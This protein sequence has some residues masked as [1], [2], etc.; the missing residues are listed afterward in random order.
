MLDALT[1]AS[2]RQLDVSDPDQRNKT[3][4]ATIQASTIQL[5]PDGRERFA[6]LAIFAEDET[7][8]RHAGGITVAGHR[9]AGRDGQ[10]GVRPAGGPGPGGADSR[11]GG[12]TTH[13]VIRDFLRADPGTARLAQLYSV[14]L[15]AAGNSPLG[16]AGDGWVRAQCGVGS[17]FS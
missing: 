15:D 4:R 16:R 10:P 6:E 17:R 7:I 8:P 1:G 12:V 9:Q 14:L 13:D 5:S 11:S 3:V 2:D